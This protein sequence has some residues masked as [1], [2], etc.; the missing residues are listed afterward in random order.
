V[1]GPDRVDARGGWVD[2]ERI[3]VLVAVMSA[4]ISAAMSAVM[5]EIEL[6]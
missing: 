4:V 1:L 6:R 5:G 2:V 3:L